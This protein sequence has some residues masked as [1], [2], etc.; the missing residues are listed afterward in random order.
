MPTNVATDATLVLSLDG[1][2]YACQITEASFTPAAPSEATPIPVACGDT[3]SEPGDPSTGSVSGSVYKDLGATGITRVLATMATTGAEAA[4]VYTE[5]DGNG[6]VMSWSGQCTVPAF[7]IDFNP[8]K[9]GKHPLNLSL[10]TSV[11]ADYVAP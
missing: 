7:G 2:D 6:E 5:T 1:T 3:V 9:Y 4:Y 8:S 10:T 11:L